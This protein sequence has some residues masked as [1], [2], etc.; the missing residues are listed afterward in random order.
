MLDKIPHVG[1]SC[2]AFWPPTLCLVQYEIKTIVHFVA[3]T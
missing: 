1:S 3:Y 2:N